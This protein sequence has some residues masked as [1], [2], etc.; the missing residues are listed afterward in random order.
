MDITF[1][2]ENKSYKKTKNEKTKTKKTL[3]NNKTP[4]KIQ[5]NKRGE[6]KFLKAILCLSI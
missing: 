3:K 6:I 2:F 5:T 4:Q 1:S